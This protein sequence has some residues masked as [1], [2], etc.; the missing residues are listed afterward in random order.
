MNDESITLR[1]ALMQTPDI[2]LYTTIRISVQA[3]AQFPVGVGLT[4]SGLNQFPDIARLDAVDPANDRNAA[5]NVRREFVDVADVIPDYPVLMPEAV[6]KIPEIKT[7][8]EPLRT[9]PEQGMRRQVEPSG[10]PATDA[11][12]PSVGLDD[13]T[14]QGQ[15][16]RSMSLIVTPLSLAASALAYEP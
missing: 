12:T 5:G 7:F 1:I 11:L 2:F 9:T 4:L 16:R 15:V 6:R 13:R 3:N 10:Q 14:P 8:V